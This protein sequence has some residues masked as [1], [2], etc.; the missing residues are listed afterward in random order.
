VGVPGDAEDVLTF[1]LFLLGRR[2]PY[3]VDLGESAGGGDG[4][5]EDLASLGDEP[6]AE[7]REAV[8]GGSA[9]DQVGGAPEILAVGVRHQIPGLGI[10]KNA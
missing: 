5:L 8:V 4:P 7:V 10:M 1:E 2:R 6:A 3:G 9:V